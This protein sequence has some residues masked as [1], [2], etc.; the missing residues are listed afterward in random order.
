MEDQNEFI[1]MIEDLTNK[2]TRGRAQSIPDNKIKMLSIDKER[3]L[4]DAEIEGT[5]IKPYKI[6]INLNVGNPKSIINH[7]CPDY[8]ARKKLNNKFC[9][10]ITKLIT[11]LRKEDPPFAF[12]LLQEIHKK[13]SIN[14]KV[15]LRKST[16]FNHFFNEDLENQLDFKYNGFEYFFDFLELD[17]SG[18]SC[19]KEILT[20]AK[21]L[22]AALRGFHGGYEGGLF[23]HILLVTNY[24]YELSNTLEYKVDTQ[25]AV[26]TAIYHDFGKISY[27]SYKK[28]QYHSYVISDREELDKIH[29]KIQK[30]Y[31]YFGRHYHVEEALAVLKRNENKLFNDDEISKA[32]IFHH[33]KWSK[34]YP[35]DMTE[36]AS[37][38]HKADMIAS[39]THYV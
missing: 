11:F 25:K 19:L 17:T 22:P 37:L 21:K 38:I 29:E 13:L 31:K 5:N 8:L 34:Y 20:E 2:N 23:D 35:I 15:K 14:Y 30:K 12:S 4:V 39:Q 27:Y 16:D 36:L 32:I 1:K 26:I 6:N 10:H 33:G 7:D 9:K 24:A 3:T 18:R 28:R